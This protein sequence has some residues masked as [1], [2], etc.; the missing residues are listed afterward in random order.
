MRLEIDDEW[1]R[2]KGYSPIGEWP[3]RPGQNI[4]IFYEDPVDQCTPRYDA[5]LAFP[6]VKP[7]ISVFGPPDRSRKQRGWYQIHPQRRTSTPDVTAKHSTGADLP[8]E[9]VRDV[10][11]KV[12]AEG[13]WPTLN[14][15]RRAFCNC[16]LVCK[17][18]ARIFQEVLFTRI[19]LHTLDDVDKLL[20]LLYESLPT[21]CIGTRY[22]RDLILQPTLTAKPWLHLLPTVLYP[23]LYHHRT[24]PMRIRVTLE[25]SGNS[26]DA[27][28]VGRSIHA[29]LPR[30]PCQP[31]FS[32]G[33][34]V[35][36]LKNVRFQHVCALLHLV[37]ELPQ[38]GELT[39]QT[40]SWPQT[41][42]ISPAYWQ[43]RLRT[44]RA[45]NVSINFANCSGYW[46]SVWLA[47]VQ[48]FWTPGTPM[49]ASARAR[50]CFEDRRRLANLFHILERSG[51]NIERTCFTGSHYLPAR[52]GAVNSMLHFNMLCCQYLH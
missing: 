35:L 40:L 7:D 14:A 11:M 17:H 44:R 13:W 8:P 2:W 52:D 31:T 42:P 47:E 23:M 49:P 45:D 9:L 34:H 37:W 27:L 32:T 43:R 15:D 3:S 36:V 24:L 6:S 22:I 21:G 19:T 5:T 51:T 46:A 50:L 39:G 48:T 28:P 41:P 30:S 29:M 16:A 26:L 25:L 12:I 4:K 1:W 38:L 10:V 33:L 18:W 20:P